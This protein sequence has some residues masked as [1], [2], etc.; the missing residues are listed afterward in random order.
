[1]TP[2]T[3]Y[4]TKKNNKIVLEGYMEFGFRVYQCTT[5]YRNSM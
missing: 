5:S 1:M 4:F 2:F 3:S